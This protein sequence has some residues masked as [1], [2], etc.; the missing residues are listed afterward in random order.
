[1]GFASKELC[2]SLLAIPGTRAD[3]CCFL[4]LLRRASAYS[5]SIGEANS[6]L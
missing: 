4:A 3:S 1:M 2:L 5:L 6:A